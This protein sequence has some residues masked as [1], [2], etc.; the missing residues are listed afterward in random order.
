MRVYFLF[1]KFAKLQSEYLIKYG[2][3]SLKASACKFLNLFI[4]SWL[5]SSK[6]ITRKGQN[7][8]ACT[9]TGKKTAKQGY[10]N[11]SK[12]LRNIFFHWLCKKE[13][14][15]WNYISLINVQNHQHTKKRR[16]EINLDSCTCRTTDSAQCSLNWS[17]HYV[18]NQVNE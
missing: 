18:Q 1:I 9:N 6:L 4:V 17:S 2:K 11:I 8:Q 15:T 12:M 7:L 13:S 10:E 5:L 3:L 16:Y 14:R